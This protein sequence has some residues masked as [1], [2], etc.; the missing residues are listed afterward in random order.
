[1][2]LDSSKARTDALRAAEELS[3][4]LPADL[5]CQNTG[6]MSGSI[7]PRLRPSNLGE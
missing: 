4:R 5:Y 7:R 6:K 1:M 3:D 2:Y